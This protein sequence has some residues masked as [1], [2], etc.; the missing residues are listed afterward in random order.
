MP[1]ERER[2][3]ARIAARAAR[4]ICAVSV[5]TRYARRVEGV[6]DNLVVPKPDRL[7]AKTCARETRRKRSFIEAVTRVIRG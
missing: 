3:V 1:R 7:D 5:A 2:L 6:G 4:P